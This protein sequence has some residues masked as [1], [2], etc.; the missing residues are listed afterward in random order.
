MATAMRSPSPL[1][2]ANPP[3]NKDM[4]KE[5]ALRQALFF[6][7]SAFSQGQTGLFFHKDGFPARFPN[8]RGPI[9]ICDIG[10]IIAAHSGPGT[11]AVFFFGDKR[12]PDQP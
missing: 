3:N 6:F 12:Q 1:S 4:K 10:T 9:R 2:T 5:P 11:V 7:V 8:L